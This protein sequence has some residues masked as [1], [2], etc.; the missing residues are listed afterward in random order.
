[1][2]QVIGFGGRS[3]TV[4]FPL[5]FRITPLR[6]DGRSSQDI[7]GWGSEMSVSLR[8]QSEMAFD[9]GP[10]SRVVDHLLLRAE[11]LS[12]IPVEKGQIPFSAAVR[13]GR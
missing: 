6:A 12:G 5:F 11:E 2:R 3:S 1:M 9:F 13:N 10:N 7:F 4:I 8:R